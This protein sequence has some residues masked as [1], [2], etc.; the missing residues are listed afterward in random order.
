MIF[1]VSNNYVFVIGSNTISSKK[2]P[3]AYIYVRILVKKYKSE[4]ICSFE[5][6]KRHL[7]PEPARVI[8][9]QSS[10]ESVSPHVSVTTP[11]AVLNLLVRYMPLGTDLLFDAAELLS[12]E[13]TLDVLLLTTA[14]FAARSG[15][16]LTGCKFNTYQFVPFSFDRPIG[17]WVWSCYHSTVWHYYLFPR[18]ARLGW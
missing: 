1:Y 2:T 6:N 13:L 16:G 18:L 9:R 11:K 3:R 17:F 10:Q 7:F 12:K 8:I 15:S 4:W 14:E 5:Y